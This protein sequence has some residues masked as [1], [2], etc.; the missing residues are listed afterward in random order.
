MTFSNS[1]RPITDD[2]KIKQYA[3][4]KFFAYC[5]RIKERK[6]NTFYKANYFLNQDMNNYWKHV[7]N[8]R[9]KRINSISLI[10][11]VRE[12]AGNSEVFKENFF[13]VNG[14][15]PRSDQQ[16]VNSYTQR[17]AYRASR[18]TYDSVTSAY[19]K[20][21]YRLDHESLHSDHLKHLSKF[22]LRVIKKFLNSCLIH[23]YMPKPMPIAVFTPRVKNKYGDLGRSTNYRE[24][25]ISSMLLKLFEYCIL[26]NF[27][28]RDILSPL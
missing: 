21:K 23:G 11:G 18:F 12:N 13:I 1:L 15:A 14:V 26:P 8:R 16:N 28:E 5:T 24:I 9:G 10:D 25:V 2:S 19:N 7:K 4:T 20:L 17:E 6:R 22:N 3:T 27:M